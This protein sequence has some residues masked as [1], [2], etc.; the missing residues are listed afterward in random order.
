MSKFRYS[1]IAHTR[2]VGRSTKTGMALRLFEKACRCCFD[3]VP[4]VTEYCLRTCASTY[5]LLRSEWMFFCSIHIATAYRAICNTWLSTT[6]PCDID[7]KYELNQQIQHKLRICMIFFKDLAAGG[8]DDFAIDNGVPL[9]YTIELRDTG[10]YGF[11]LP[12]SQVKI[13]VVCV[14]HLFS[15]NRYKVRQ[16][17]LYKICLKWH[18]EFN[19]LWF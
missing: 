10:R 14:K 16:L 13:D 5:S 4:I 2:H 11:A 6:N 7:L 19:R 3:I 18:I 1:F 17:T 8:S 12:E 15:Y 9:S